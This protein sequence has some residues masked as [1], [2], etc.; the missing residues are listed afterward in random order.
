[1]V[2]LVTRNQSSERPASMGDVVA[3]EISGGLVVLSSITPATSGSGLNRR[4]APSRAPYYHVL[5]KG[6]RLPTKPGR[7]DDFGWPRV[8]PDIP[9]PEPVRRARP[10]PPN[11]PPHRAAKPDCRARQRKDEPQRARAFKP[12]LGRAPR[13][14]ADGDRVRA[15]C[16]G[17]RLLAI[18][19][20][21]AQRRL[22]GIAQRRGQL[23]AGVAA[24]PLMTDH[25][26]PL[27]GTPTS[28][29]DAVDFWFERRAL[30]GL[31]H[32]A[33][34]RH[35]LEMLLQFGNLFAYPLL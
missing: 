31:E 17:P 6:E 27:A 3:D 28:D 23:F 16:A 19:L 11:P 25:N 26:G 21:L 10:N 12:F 7:A 33:A 8:E 15:G 14:L 20:D 18:P 9:E 32:D 1:M 24:D 5:I 22:E 29:L 34:A 35:A 30:G 2:A 13:H 4:Q